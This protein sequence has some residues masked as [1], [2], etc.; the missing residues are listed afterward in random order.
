MAIEVFDGRQG[1]TG[2]SRLVKLR[3]ICLPLSPEFWD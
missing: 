3:E 2:L 1:I